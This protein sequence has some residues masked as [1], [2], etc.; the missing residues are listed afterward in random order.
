MESSS[1]VGQPICDLVLFTWDVSEVYGGPHPFYAIEDLL[2]IRV[3]IIDTR[4]CLSVAE[5]NNQL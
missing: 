4:L 2:H 5:I 1:D 3:K